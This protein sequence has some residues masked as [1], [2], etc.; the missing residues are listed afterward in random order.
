MV[1]VPQ[2]LLDQLPTPQLLESLMGPLFLLP[3]PHHVLCPEACLVYKPSQSLGS[4][5]SQ[6]LESG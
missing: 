4:Q 5:A 1:V 2:Q 3:P 6:E